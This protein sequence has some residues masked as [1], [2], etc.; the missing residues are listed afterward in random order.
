LS[1]SPDVPPPNI[2]DGVWKSPFV[3]QLAPI[4]HHE[5][6]FSHFDD[7]TTDN[8][9]PDDFSSAGSTPFGLD[10]SL[11]P[12]STPPDAASPIELPGNEQALGDSLLFSP[13]YRSPSSRNSR[14]PFAKKSAGLQGPTRLSS[15]LPLTSDP[16]VKP[17]AC[18]RERC[19]P[20]QATSSRVCFATSKELFEHSKA[21]HAGE[22]IGDRPFRCAL[23]GCGKSWKNLNGLQYH[24]QISTAHFRHALSSSFSAQTSTEGGEP[25]LAPTR[26]NCEAEASDEAKRT[27][28][29]HHPHCFKAYRQLSGLRYHLKH[30]HPQE[31]PIQLE[32]VPP[33]LARQIPAK[34]KKMR[35][36]DSPE[37]DP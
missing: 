7:T 30:G 10:S 22:P 16:S 1:N 28:L 17:Y 15:M 20:A 9:V 25:P 33:T 36:K 35:R 21:E 6:Q 37:P 26:A 4:R 31:M 19:W 34:T 23:A 5:Q 32:V 18:G 27:Y 13:H 2:P 11:S 14:K 3:P 29:C 12:T 24:L 8:N